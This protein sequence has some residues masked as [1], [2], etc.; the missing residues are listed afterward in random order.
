M[1]AMVE[2]AALWLPILLSAVF[3]FIASSV[4]HMA[5]P[6]HKG[7]YRKLPAE[8]QVLDSMRE[9]VPPGQYMFPGADSMKEM[10][11]PQMVAKFERGPVGIMIV[12]AKG[13]MSMG[14]AL[15]SW[16][17]FCLVIGVCTAYVAGLV[18]PPG[19]GRVFRIAA[20]VAT[21]CHAFSSVNDSIWKG[22]SWWTTL[23]FVFDGIVYG[24]VTGA[25][26]AWLWPAA[27]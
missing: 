4:I 16:F 5:L 9:V 7:D 27:V 20:T 11:S 8:D 1:L 2:L 21:L 14:K 23:K 22:L 18:L 25:T 26:F 3:V 17:V 6:I 12:R 24:L 15:G 13:S 19:D 10:S